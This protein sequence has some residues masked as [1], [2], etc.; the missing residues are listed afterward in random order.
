MSKDC[1]LEISDEVNIRFRGLDVQTRRKLSSA[2]EYFLPYAR[3]TPA[4]K[5]GRWNGKVSYCDVGGR[6][7]LNLLDDLLPVVQDAGYLIEVDDLRESF[8]FTFDE[9]AAD[10][11]NHIL[12]PKGHVHE[13]EPIDIRDHQLKVING[14]L[15]H[16]QAIQEVSTGAGK[17]VTYD[18][19]I[20]VEIHSD[21][22]QFLINKHSK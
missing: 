18:T 7:Y 6:S 20:N 15:G 9:I 4:Y 22:S 8:D 1:I 10:S 12:W 19:N 11:Y 5:L 3:H 21:F 14:Y 17:C 13:G 2:L 16:P